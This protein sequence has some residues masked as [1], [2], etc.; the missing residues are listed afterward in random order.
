MRC[1]IW[2][3]ACYTNRKGRTAIPGHYGCYRT[4]SRTKVEVSAMK[5]PAYNPGEGQW[6]GK[7]P[8]LPAGM[9][10]YPLLWA[11]LADPTYDDG[12]SR[13][14]GTLVIFVEHG[15]LKGCLSDRDVDTVLFR[16]A[17]GPVDLLMALEEA[18]GGNG[19]D[20]R[21]SRAAKRR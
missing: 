5:R 6:L 21:Q 17:D 9:G 4:G 11:M 1:S 10:K 20:W 12:S 2:C 8:P 3:G 19:A 13:E 15:Q 16:S 14:L 18:L 7:C